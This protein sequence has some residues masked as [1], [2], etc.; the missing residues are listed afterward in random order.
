MVPGLHVVD[1][2]RNATLPGAVGAAI[3]RALGF[4]AVPYD[5]A[6]TVLTNGSQLVY[7]ALEAV[8]GMGAAGRHHLKRPVVVVAADLAFSHLSSS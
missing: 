2:R 5:L 3:K 7:G 6:A 4:D 8:E 1:D